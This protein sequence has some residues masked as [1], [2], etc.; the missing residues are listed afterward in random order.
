MRIFWDLDP[1]AYRLWSHASLP[2][3]VRQT[4]LMF[5]GFMNGYMFI[6]YVSGR[7]DHDDDELLS[8]LSGGLHPKPLWQVLAVKGVDE[9]PGAAG[10]RP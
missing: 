4:G 9:R 2:L 6:G 8:L 7:L 5:L 1:L 10:E 3:E